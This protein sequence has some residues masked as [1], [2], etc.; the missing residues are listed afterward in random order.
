MSSSD[1]IAIASVIVATLAFFTT[2]WQSW[3]THRHSRLS[4]RP[5]LAWHT[6]RTLKSDAFEVVTILSNKGL[7]PAIVKE[8]YFT[9]DGQ[10]YKTPSSA[11]NVV[12]TL[13]LSLIPED[14]GCR[15]PEH[16]LPGVGNAILPGEE[17]TI[18]RLAFKPVVFDYSDELD[19]RMKRVEF[20]VVFEDIYENRFVFRTS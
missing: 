15:I 10:H 5:L 18:A 4:V 3:L 19:L 13:A 9:L 7:G 6:N 12:E 8:R 16:G 17:I 20:V 14:W 1:V 2:V 11:S